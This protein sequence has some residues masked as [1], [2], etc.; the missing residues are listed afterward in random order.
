MHDTCGRIPGLRRQKQ[1]KREFKTILSY[2]ATL[3]LTWATW[4]S[5]LKTIDII[6]RWSSIKTFPATFQ[7]SCLSIL[8][9]KTDK[10]H[11]LTSES[12][13]NSV[14]PKYFL[15]QQ[16]SLRAA[17]CAG[18]SSCWVVRANQQ[19]LRVVPPLNN[20]NVEW[21]DWRG[22]RQLFCESLE[23]SDGLILQRGIYL[24][25]R[26]YFLSIG[27]VR[28]WNVRLRKAR[29]PFFGNIEKRRG[30]KTSCNQ[31]MWGLCCQEAERWIHCF[32]SKKSSVLRNE[33]CLLSPLALQNREL[34]CSWGT[35][36]AS[37]ALII[38][39]RLFPPLSKHLL[40][41]FISV[42]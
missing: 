35:P 3:R 20:G 39:P 12:W 38:T 7:S 15:S 32:G 13:E 25:L 2:I 9:S 31:F 10:S 24:N 22:A 6:A 36:R 40:Q 28:L 19:Q 34:Q 4:G 5:V 30:K 33:V 11:I 27:T 14:P 29:M 8:V 21:C 41:L 18:L 42:L 1:E 16:S 37:P 26:K 23:D 17:W